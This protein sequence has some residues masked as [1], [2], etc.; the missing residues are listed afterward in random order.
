[1]I[2]K[3]ESCFN[4]K[5]QKAVCSNHGTQL[6]K[7]MA[8]SSGQYINHLKGRN[9]IVVWDGERKERGSNS[10]VRPEGELGHLSNC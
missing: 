7:R 2:N 8:I 10:A 4:G 5:L 9:P 6:G 1:M 3:I